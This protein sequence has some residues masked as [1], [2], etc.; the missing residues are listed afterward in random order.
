MRSYDRQAK[1]QVTADMKL[2]KRYA[3]GDKDA[4]E[5]MKIIYLRCPR[6]DR[7]ECMKQIARHFRATAVMVNHAKYTQGKQN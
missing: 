2:L 3:F 5:E 1:K 6:A 7:A 4:F